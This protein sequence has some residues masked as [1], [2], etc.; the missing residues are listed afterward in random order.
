[1]VDRLPTG[2]SLVE[3]SRCDA[4]AGRLGLLDLLPIVSGLR[5]TCRHCGVRL[6]GHLLRIELAAT[7]AALIAILFGDGDV[8]I[9]V[10]AVYLWCLV[11]LFYCDLQ[12]FRL[13]DMLTMGLFLSGIA[14]AV[15]NSNRGLLDGAT[16]AAAG[17][18]AF[19]AIRWAYHLYRG[20]EGLGL[21]D[22]TLMAGLGA[23]LGVVAVPWGTLIA[24]LLALAVTIVETR[25][26][27]SDHA[28]PFGAY[29]CTAAVLV[30]LCQAE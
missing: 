2:R 10:L 14:L 30:F 23:G 19:A 17:V 8:G 3:S 28:I 5:G 24:A 12:H 20:V 27:Q 4:C 13:P 1:V 7:A 9:V 25:R 18:V 21:G 16:S 26:L 15:L 11:G 29:L 22:V 6:A